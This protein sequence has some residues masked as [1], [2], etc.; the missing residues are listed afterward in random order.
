[1]KSVTRGHDSVV[2][3]ESFSA[4]VLFG[5]YRMWVLWVLGL[6]S[7][8]WPVSD[9]LAK[10]HGVLRQQT[11]SGESLTP[12]PAFGLFVQVQPLGKVA[13]GVEKNSGWQPVRLPAGV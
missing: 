4:G 6:G 10:L 3:L 12:R 2:A 7:V 11:P 13:R 9:Q 8:R 5:C 1:M